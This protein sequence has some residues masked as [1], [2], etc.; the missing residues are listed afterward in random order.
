LIDA[1]SDFD[2]AS[3]EAESE[4]E[5]EFESDPPKISL[6]VPQNRDTLKSVAPSR[7]TPSNITMKRGF[8]NTQKAKQRVAEAIGAESTGEPP[9]KQSKDKGKKEKWYV[10]IIDV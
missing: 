3:S 6:R 5:S 9:H 2:R 4:S 7:A 1:H 10:A 8:L